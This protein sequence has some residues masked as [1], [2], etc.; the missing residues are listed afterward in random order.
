M[1]L[2][3]SDGDGPYRCVVFSLGVVLKQ[4]GAI[5]CLTDESSIIDQGIIQ[6]QKVFHSR[7]QQFDSEVSSTEKRIQIRFLRSYGL[8]FKPV[9]FR[10]FDFVCAME[11]SSRTSGRRL[12]TTP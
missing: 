6:A 1:H 5:R 3:V 2:L 7:L 11:V 12:G 9:L 4:S 10:M 8:D